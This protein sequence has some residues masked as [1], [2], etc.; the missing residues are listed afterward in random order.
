MNSRMGDKKNILLVITKSNFGG[1]QKYVHDLAIELKKNNHNIK[2]AVG[3]N[4]ILIDKLLKEDIDVI[5]IP[6]LERD[7]SLINDIKTFFFLYKIFKINKPEVVH[8]NSSKIGGIGGCAA[9]IARIKNIIFTAHGWAFNENRSTV[10]K[11]IIKILYWITIFLSHKTIVVSNSMKSQIINWPLFPLIHKKIK[12]IHNGINCPKFLTKEDTFNKLDIKNED[13]KIIIG[14]IAELHKI[15]GHTYILEAAKELPFVNFVFIG[16][17]EEKENLGKIVK[18]QNI[19]NITFKGFLDNAAIYLKT[20]DYFLL[21]SLS[22]GL[23][24]CLLEAGL[25]EVPV[26]AT[27]VGGIPEI[28]K[29]KYNGILIESKNSNAIV[30]AVDFLIGNPEEARKYAENLKKDIQEN[31]S[32][33]K[34]VSN[35]IALYLNSDTIN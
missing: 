35:T 16:D 8:L 13:N 5:K 2:V 30:S 19:K 10:S 9:R 11:K 22:E 28:I 18:E 17:G 3:G 25:A 27:N 33:N 24:I 14:T 29:D 6:N 4:G 1:A 20:F 31:F 26:I 7:I 21:P 12:V 23:A 15:K 32:F 34:M